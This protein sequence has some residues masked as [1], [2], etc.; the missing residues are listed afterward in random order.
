MLDSKH[1]I[2]IQL[3]LKRRAISARS[4]RQCR[5]QNMNGK[6]VNQSQR[7]T[8]E[9]YHFIYTNCDDRLGARMH[10]VV[11]IVRI[12]ETGGGK[13]IQK[14]K[15]TLCSLYIYDFMLS[16]DVTDLLFRSIRQ[17]Y[18][19]SS[20]DTVFIRSRVNSTTV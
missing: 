9:F 16:D 13:L 10:A 18:M 12:N 4:N 3:A 20:H 14:L 15:K 7:C 8:Y 11:C 17:I 1:K 2:P 19:W 6:Y 5:L